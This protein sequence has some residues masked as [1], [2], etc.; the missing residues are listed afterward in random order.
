M[1]LFKAANQERS[2]IDGLGQ[3]F[4]MVG[5]II[6]TSFVNAINWIIGALQNLWNYIVTLGGLLP[7]N[8]S[9]TGNQIIDT[10]LRVL[11][12][13]FTLPLQIAMVFTNII[14]KALGF[15]NNFAQRMLTAASNSVS[16]FMSQISQLPGKLWTELNNMLSAVSQW[17]ATLPQKFWDAG[18]NAVK[19]FLSALG[20]ASPGTMQR[21]LIW[22]ISEMGNRVPG[23]SKKLLSNVSDLGSNIVDSFGDPTLG[24][25]YED[26]MNSQLETVT[27]GNNANGN[28]Y[29]FY[30]YGDMDNE[31]RMEKFVDAVI[32]RLHFENSTAGRT[33]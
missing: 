4:I 29:N 31:D 7:E 24:L 32:R 3:T 9:I 28:T 10:I 14:A 5:Q 18:V 20:I 33:V 2:A 1:P 6:Y 16:R 21:M 25:N 19:N 11:A 17:A 23:E 15:G 13:L 26:T 30:H 12:F 27:T 22:E 8:V